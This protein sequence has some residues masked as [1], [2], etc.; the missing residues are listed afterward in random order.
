MDRIIFDYSKLRGKIREVYGSEGK[1]ANAIG[2][3]DTTLSLI[4]NNKSEFKQQQ[5]KVACN[6]LGIQPEEIDDYFFA[7][8]VKEN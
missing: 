8:E 6:L 4:L 2:I 1:F 3:T 7:L 5:I